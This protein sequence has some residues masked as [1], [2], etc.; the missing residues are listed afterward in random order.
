MKKILIVIMIFSIIFSLSFNEIYANKLIPESKPIKVKLNDKFL[1]FDVQPIIYK[2]RTMVPMRAIFEY[3]GCLVSWHQKTQTVTAYK[4]NMYIKLQIGK[5]VA[6]KNGKSFILDAQPIIKN[7]RTLVPLRFIAE[8]LGIIVNWD[9]ENRIVS[10]SYDD[11]ISKFK[12][13][14]NVLYKAV[15]F[16]KYGLKL[17]VPDYFENTPEKPYSFK[18]EDNIQMNIDFIK[19]DK[20]TT[21]DDF[22]ENHKKLLLEKFKDKIIF[23]GRDKF[24]VNNLNVNAVYLKNSSY[25]PEINQA[26][27]YVY[28]SK[29]IYLIT[30]SYKNDANDSQLLDVFYNIVNSIK[31]SNLSVDLEEE[32]YIEYDNFFKLGIH[33][34]TMIYSNMEVKNKFRFKGTIESNDLDYLFVIVKK[35]NDSMEFKIPVKENKFDAVIYTPFGLGK[36]NI[37]VGTPIDKNNTSEYIMQFSVINTSNKQIRYLIPSRFVEKNDEIIKLAE[38]ITKNDINEYDK[39]KS[40]FK[41]IA[42]NITY[43][44]YANT[45]KPRSAVETLRDKKGDC[46]EISYLYAALLRAL[47]IP[48]KLVSG[49]I[50]KDFHV[51]NEVK[52]NGKW[53]IVDCTWGSGYISDNKTYIK[54][55]NLNY[56]NPNRKEYESKFTNI[57][58]LPY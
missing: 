22:T 53:I 46:D 30:F 48:A 56:F 34:D 31:I 11:S 38:E 42:E 7:S 2:N 58:Y 17:M 6:Y 28:N 44:I 15:K 54:K 10:L 41:W 27:Y 12:T 36:H 35:N 52:I 51:W 40:I 57:E 49:K 24:K 3:L 16:K 9:E 43:D 23:T 37:D 14:D 8:S 25:N 13:I 47:D 4:D 29:I 5:N 50:Q 1:K 33:L 20:P 39:A 32:H 55:L 18:Y 19:L 21:L 26:I 45:E